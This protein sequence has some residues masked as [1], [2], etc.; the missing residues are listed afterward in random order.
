[1]RYKI[2]VRASYAA[3]ELSKQSHGMFCRRNCCY[4][5][6][7]V[8]TNGKQFGEVFYSI[9]EEPSRAVKYI[10]YAT[11]LLIYHDDKI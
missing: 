8:T 7:K 6:T 11:K 9:F 1:M 2:H 4:F 3:V 5:R 10:Y